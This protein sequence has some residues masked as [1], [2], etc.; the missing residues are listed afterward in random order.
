MQEILIQKLHEYIR[1]NNPDI[2]ISLQEEGKVADFLSGKLAAINDLLEKLIMEEKPAYIIEELCMKVM[3]A[4]LRPSK[5]NYIK[6]ILA[7]EFE[8]I[9][10]QLE[11]SGTLMYEVINL[12]AFCQPVFETIGFTED[13]EED[14]QLRNAIIGSI[15]MYFEN[16]Q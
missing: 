10:Q 2:L 8:I 9:H 12:I 4:D 1:T 14:N 7:E 6:A 16:N 11:R 13:N 5:Y 15:Q 3:T